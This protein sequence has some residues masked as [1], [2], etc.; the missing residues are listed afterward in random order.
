MKIWKLLALLLGILVFTTV[1]AAIVIHISGV[2]T[3]RKLEEKLRQK[4]ISKAIIKKIDQCSNVVL[5][6]DLDSKK[7]LEI[8][9]DEL[10]DDLKKG[11][12]IFVT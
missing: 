3:H 6:K 1:S 7:I 11:D 12:K 9:G 5:L 8:H 4:K 10:S 2:I